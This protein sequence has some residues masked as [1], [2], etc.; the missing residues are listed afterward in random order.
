MTLFTLRW[1][2]KKV[3][4]QFVNPTFNQLASVGRHCLILK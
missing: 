2:L 3:A 1:G 4:R